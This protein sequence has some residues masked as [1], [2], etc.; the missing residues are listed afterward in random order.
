VT[1]GCCPCSRDG[2][3]GGGGGEAAR[4]LSPCLY[5]TK[6]IHQLCT[7]GRRCKQARIVTPNNMKAEDKA[8]L[9]P[10]HRNAQARGDPL[11]PSGNYI[12][13]LL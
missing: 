4:R 10:K 2:G 12:N 11:R 8:F 13:H 1:T 9:L 5:R 3:G 7:G 6:T